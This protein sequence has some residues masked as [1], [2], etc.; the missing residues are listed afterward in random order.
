M[1]LLKIIWIFFVINALVS[2]R[3]VKEAAS[4]TATSIP[5]IPDT[6]VEQAANVGPEVSAKEETKAPEVIP[7]TNLA[8]AAPLATSPAKEKPK[9]P[10]NS[11]DNSTTPAP[12]PVTTPGAPAPGTTVPPAP[13]ATTPK[14][15]NRGAETFVMNFINL[16][17]IVSVGIILI[18]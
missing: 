5:G 18:I 1:E 17:I 13:G 12:G 10:Q 11:S 7:P 8:I 14:P 6:P 3:S 2:G 15:T 16:A 4:D 9:D